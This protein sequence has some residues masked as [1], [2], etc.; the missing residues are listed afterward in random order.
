MSWLSELTWSN[1][2]EHLY[3]MIAGDAELD[4]T[5][6]ST[7]DRKQGFLYKIAEKIASLTGASLPEIEESDVGKALGVDADGEQAW[8]ALD[9][10][11]DYS[12]AAA[13]AVLTI[14]DGTPTWV[15]PEAPAVEET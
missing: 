14:V 12:D 4:E 2:L 9:T 1:R 15:A 13:G 6:P 7:Y 5:V 10:L 3:A 8:A 11:P